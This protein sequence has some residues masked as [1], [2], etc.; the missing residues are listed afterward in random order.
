MRS[1]VD[2]LG[3]GGYVVVDMSRSREPG[4]GK[5]IDSLACTDQVLRDF[6]PPFF[7]LLV[8]IVVTSQLRYR[9]PKVTGI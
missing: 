6:V 1:S 9:D 3:V 8:D 2:G 5:Q 4:P 7:V